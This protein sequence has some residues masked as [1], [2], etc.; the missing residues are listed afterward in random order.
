MTT[1]VQHGR[2]PVLRRSDVGKDTDVSISVQIVAGGVHR[3][4]WAPVE[5]GPLK[6]VID[7]KAHGSVKISRESHKIDIGPRRVHI[8]T[9][10][11]L[12]KERVLIMPWL[13]SIYL[14]TQV[15]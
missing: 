2:R 5:I 12:L 1:L 7:G 3:F 9:R 6:D 11:G 8:A 14:D 13:K 10:G 4:M 15:S